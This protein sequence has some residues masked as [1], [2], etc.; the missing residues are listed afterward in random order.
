MLI[1]ERYKLDSDTLGVTISESVKVRAGGARWQP[2]YYFSTPQNAL[3][4]LL[5]NEVMGTGM[6]DLKTVCQKIDDLHRLVEGLEG[7]PQT[8]QPCKDAGNGKKRGKIPA[9]EQPPIIAPAK[10][11]PQGALL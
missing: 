1:N 4:W 6:A 8:V 7:L 11:L 2:K 5:T 10:T 9:A 3:K